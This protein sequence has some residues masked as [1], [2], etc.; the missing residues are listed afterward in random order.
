MTEQAEAEQSIHEQIESTLNAAEL[1]V[2][3]VDVRTVRDR[4]VRLRTNI[5][6]GKTSE[7]VEVTL[8]ANAVSLDALADEIDAYRDVLAEQL[9]YSRQEARK[10]NQYQ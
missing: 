6:A 8:E 5:T 10:A 7:R 4:G 1:D 2:E 9:E 3:D